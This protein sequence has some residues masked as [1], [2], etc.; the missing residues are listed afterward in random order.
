MRFSPPIYLLLACLALGGCWRQP[1][2]APA[3][4]PSAAP[5]AAGESTAA[6]ADAPPADRNPINQLKPATLSADAIGGTPVNT[7]EEAWYR[8]RAAI[9]KYCAD[10]NL[11]P[12]SF[13]QKDD[14]VE[15]DGH[16]SVTWFGAIHDQGRYIQI[17]VYKDGRAEIVP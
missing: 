5:Q 6:P 16:Y 13:Y 14:L 17:N 7:P 9:E 1:N 2:P 8:A 4:T 15:V 12:Q 10:N 11:P 3:A